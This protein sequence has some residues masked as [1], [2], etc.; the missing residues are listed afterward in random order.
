MLNNLR[1]VVKESVYSSFLKRSCY[2]KHY[3]TS[4]NFW[5]PMWSLFWNVSISN[6]CCAM[7]C[8]ICNRCWNWYMFVVVEIW[9]FRND[10]FFLGTLSQISSETTVAT[11]L[12]ICMTNKLYDLFI[13]P[14]RLSSGRYDDYNRFIR[15]TSTKGN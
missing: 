9:F 8:F 13:H 12:W 14:M 11:R 3:T 6:S 2:I 5:I 10:S 15:F 4:T 1:I 7:I